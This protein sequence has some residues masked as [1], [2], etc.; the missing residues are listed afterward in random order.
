MKINKKRIELSPSR[1]MLSHRSP[2]VDM[3]APLAGTLRRQEVV[4]TSRQIAPP[5]DTP[6]WAIELARI[7]AVAVCFFV[8]QW[9]GCGGWPLAP[10]LAICFAIGLGL[11]AIVRYGYHMAIALFIASTGFW[12][13]NGLSVALTLAAAVGETSI[14]I[15]AASFMQWRGLDWRLRKVEYIATLCLGGIF[16]GAAAS[17]LLHETALVAGGLHDGDGMWARW[18][19]AWAAMAQGVLIGMPLVL[20]WLHRARADRSSI[21]A[22]GLSLLVVGMLLFA[23][24]VLGKFMSF[25]TARDAMLFALFPFGIWAAHRYAPR[26]VTLI[27]LSVA[28]GALID[29]KLGRGIGTGETPAAALGLFH[30][31]IACFALVTLVFSVVNMERRSGARALAASETRF[32]KLT[33]LANDWYWEQDAGLRFTLVSP[34][35]AAIGVN[36]ADISGRH[37]WDLP[38][39]LSEAEWSA[40]RAIVQARRPF[41][42][43]L[44]TRRSGTGESRYFV[45]SGDPVIDHR[46]HFTG[47]RGVVRE[48]TS[49]R[50]AAEA[51][52]QSEQ[53]YASVFSNSSAAMLVVRIDE[54][55]LYRIESCNPSAE[56]LL[57][58]PARAMAGSTPE[59]CFEAPLAAV[60]VD[61]VKRC[62]VANA[63]L[64]EEHELAL[65]SGTKHVVE[66]LVPMR[67]ESARVERVI[68]IAIDISDQRRIE[69]RARVSEQLFTRV[70]HANPTPIAFSRLTDGRITE[71]NAAW[72][73]LF[74]AVRSSVVGRTVH[75][76][77]V[78]ASGEDYHGI[79]ATMLRS[80]SVR[81]REF[82]VQLADA[83]SLDILYSGELLELGGETVVVSSVVDVSAMKRHEDELRQAKDNF[84]RVFHSSPVPMIVSSYPE[85]RYIELN[86]AWLEF[87]G[88]S[89]E[90]ALGR[91]AVELGV[92]PKSVAEDNAWMDFVSGRRVRNVE[93]R[94]RRKSGEWADV[95]VSAEL[96]EL[97]GDARVVTSII[98]ITKRKET[99]QLLQMSEARFRDFAE[100]AGEY[101]WETDLEWRFS[102]VSNRVESV[103]GYMP[104]EMEGRLISE[105]APPGEDDR[106][107]KEVKTARRLDGSFRNLEHR[108]V[109]K[110]GQI[111]WQLVNAVPMRD[112]EERIVGYRGT[113]L[114][115]TE[116]KLAEQWF[117]ELATHDQ[118]TGLPNRRLF[119]EQLVR[120]TA[121]AQRTGQLAALLFI[122][123]DRFKTVND[124]LGHQ[125][126]DALLKEMARRLSAALRKGDTL[127]RFGGDEFVILLEGLRSPADAGTVAEKIVAEVGAP[128]DIEGH[129]LTVSCSIGLALFPN[130]ATDVSTLMRYADAAMYAAKAAGRDT[131]RFFSTNLHASQSPANWLGSELRMA[132]D[133]GE[134]R[135]HYQPRVAIADGRVTA[136][137]ASLRWHHPQRGMLG[138]ER[139]MRVADEVGLARP[140]TEWLLDHALAQIRE[141]RAVPEL[142]IPVV[143][144]FDGMAFTTSLVETVRSALQRQ[145]LP[146]DTAQVEISESAALRDLE[147][148]RANIDYLHAIGVKVLIDEFGTGYAAE[149]YLRRLRVDAVKISA[150]FVSEIVQSTEE[151]RHVR[152]LIELAHAEGVSAIAEGVDSA[153]QLTLLASFGCVE[154]AGRHYLGPVPPAEF[155]Q[156][157]LRTTNISRLNP[158]RTSRV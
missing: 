22:L 53:R 35:V 137:E 16:I 156:R 87:F 91:T 17:A 65:R 122:D 96:I 88:F 49:E 125:V 94:V 83:S 32:R 34:G 18:L 29:L 56:A 38:F 84:S 133:R 144:S 30:G 112:P 28:I 118:L 90:E 67:N 76:L 41:R 5:I 20:L 39:S 106:F 37:F 98:D 11:A 72:L 80:G 129:R 7:V 117:E 158:R 142:R 57:E 119:E 46:G 135:V 104:K 70:F 116:R 121:H 60:F 115:V 153:E 15:A 64:T 42:D 59:Q 150:S 68:V 13:V 8:L 82:R 31:F 147:A 103:L 145:G 25:T 102:F 146:G 107:H 86:D 27:N 55:G 120:G 51:L 114:D 9:I 109:T 40:H 23:P 101:V 124:T 50:R 140:L 79:V 48:I 74:G 69:E 85:R 47:Y 136:V 148:C 132:L 2:Q 100:A 123:L 154:Y 33:E 1:L 131:Y 151:R 110:T 44:L 52:R 97:S 130:D 111:V 139:F 77:G 26:E 61:R 95:L 63:R 21:E 141:W 92:W 152:A 66:T 138:P 89:R 6:R 12:L 105:F 108:V 19:V 4:D 81:N 99:E 14:L 149:R 113:A 71:V 73:E 155:E 24:T 78:I 43:L 157:A 75:E 54:A 128:C 10:A 36:R 45:T 143:F 134:F 126:G 62:V 58:L 93:Q 3:S 127:S